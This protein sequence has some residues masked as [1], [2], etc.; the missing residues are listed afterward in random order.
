MKFLKNC[1]MR[2]FFKSFYKLIYFL[3]LLR[4]WNRS[5][6]CI[7]LNMDLNLFKN[8]KYALIFISNRPHAI[9]FI[10]IV[11]LFLI[12]LLTFFY[13][14]FPIIVFRLLNF[15]FFFI[16]P[17]KNFICSFYWFKSLKNYFFCFYC[18]EYVN[19]RFTALIF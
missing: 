15:F 3:Y 8:F 5:F 19:I 4:P 12:Y 13:F 11:V 14:I 9:F 10:T 1:F 16:S 7:L 18:N 6:L 17:S 2:V